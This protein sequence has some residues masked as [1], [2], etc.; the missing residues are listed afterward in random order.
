MLDKLKREVCESNRALPL[1]GLVTSTS[2]NV[3]G[4]DRGRKLMVIKPSGMAFQ[5]LKPRDMVVI[6]LKGR[7]VEGRLMPSVDAL[8]HLIVYKNRP[9][10]LGIV[11]THSNYATS[12][13][14]LGRPLPVYTT[15]HAD[16]FGEPIPVSRFASSD[17][18]E[19]G[20]AIVKTLGKSRV[21]AVL[22]RNHG[23]FTFGPSPT[24]ALKAAV[25]VEDIAKTCHLALLLGNPKRIPPREAKKW[26][27]RY[28]EIYGQ[29][30]SRKSVYFKV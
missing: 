30:G 23:V 29:K 10:F 6:D 28:H 18:D 25:M 14:L 7:V 8:S 24:S 26:Y 2:G 19:V 17:P 12:F 5:R 4:F 16:E 20:K 11:H 27:R 22:I 21:P 1:K 15:A 9:D 3:S 13:A